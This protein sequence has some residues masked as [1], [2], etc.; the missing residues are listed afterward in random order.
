MNNDYDEIDKLIFEYFKNNQEIPENIT[1]CINNALKHKS[2]KHKIVLLVRKIA[3]TILC[4]LT[5]TG[6]VV[7]ANDIKE[8]FYNLK[9]N[10]FGTHNDGITT[11]IENSYDEKIDMEYIESNNVKLKIEQILLDDYNLGITCKIQ[12][13]ELEENSYL[14]NIYKIEFKNT[15]I[16]DDSNNV[17]YAKYENIEEF[18]KYC[19]I[20]NLDKG[21]WGQGYSN[22]S[23][24]GKIKNIQNNNLIFSFYTG[25]EKF[26]ISKK[27]YIKFDTIY[28]FN[29]DENL[30]NTI[31]GVWEMEVDIEKIA[32][33]RNTIEYSIVDINDN[34]T[35]VTKANLSMSNMKLELITSSEKIDFE[36][37]KGKNRDKLNVVDMIPFHDIYIE[38]PNGD[39]FYEIG[40]NGYD[41]LEDGKIK[42]YT[43]FNYTYFDEQDNIK[44]VLPTNT[45]EIIIAE[46]KINKDEAQ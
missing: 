45:G 29:R 16:M 44:L 23:Y 11:A 31:N 6:G 2:I 38:T 14:E 7:F 43:T 28:L 35:T 3:I 34:K 27:M 39:K 10:I 12:F 20:N 33:K 13:N 17:L 41:N 5:I 18:Y 25:S 32:K 42:Y 37:L 21:I 9:E 24:S 8:L 1:N 36:K 4:I 46:L 30:N 26:P 22:G 19:E 40:Q 15:L